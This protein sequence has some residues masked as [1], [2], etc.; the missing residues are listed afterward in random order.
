MPV[1]KAEAAPSAESPVSAPDEP[2]LLLGLQTPVIDPLPPEAPPKSERSIDDML[3]QYFGD[4]WQNAKKIAKCE[5]GLKP[6]AHNGNAKT[7]D[8]SYG[9][10]QINIYGSLAKSRPSGEWLMVAEN[11]IEYASRMYH[12]QGWAPWTCK[13]VLKA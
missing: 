2:P 8:N 10:F 3:K 6:N 1:P 12:A 4:Q 13:R 9:L 5:S 7:K 11:N